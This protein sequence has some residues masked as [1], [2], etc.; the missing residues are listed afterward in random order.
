MF[1]STSSRET[2]GLSGKQINCFPRDHTLSVYCSL[3]GRQGARKG[4]G[5]SRA[6]SEGSAPSWFCKSVKSNKI[7]RV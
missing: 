2:S 6:R 4:E 5:K 3:R 1:S 7:S